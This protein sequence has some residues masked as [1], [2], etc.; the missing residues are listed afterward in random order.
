MG[1]IGVMQAFIVNDGFSPRR[2]RSQMGITPGESFFNDFVKYLETSL[3]IR[4]L[5]V[6]SANQTPSIKSR[7]STLST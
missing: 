6:S 1:G 3:P 7:E 5:K 4:I 2:F